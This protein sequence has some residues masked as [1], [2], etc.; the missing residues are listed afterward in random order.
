MN[1]IAKAACTCHPNLYSNSNTSY[2][3]TVIDKKVA[4]N[5]MSPPPTT[6]WRRRKKGSKNRQ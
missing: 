5:I 2:A 3:F 4:N 6:Q 1:S